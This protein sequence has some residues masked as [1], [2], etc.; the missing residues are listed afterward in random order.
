MEQTLV[1][2]TLPEMGESVTE[3]SIVEWR[4]NVGD[5]VAEGDA[6][7]E[8]TTDKVDVEVPSTTS[9]VVT[10]ILA[11][12]G[13]TVAVGSVLAE[14]DSSKTDGRVAPAAAGNGAPAPKAPP[15]A[16]PA[17]RPT[18]SEGIADPQARRIAERLGVDLT[19]VRGSGPDGLILRS[20]VLEQAENAR[21]PAVAQLALPPIPAGAKLT[22]LRGP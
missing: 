11:R 21:R 13:Q 12:E 5:F 6:L 1:S 22:P 8:V 9:G 3:G 18:T 10:R 14:I 17:A 15:R 4:K 7:V 16:P 20:D 2:V 19:R